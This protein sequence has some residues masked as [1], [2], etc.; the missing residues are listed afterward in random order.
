MTGVMGHH[1]NASRTELS[2]PITNVMMRYDAAMSSSSPGLATRRERTRAATLAEI[3]QVALALMRDQGTTDV[4]FT[5]IARAMGL[6]APALYRYYADRDALLTDLITDGYHDLAAELAAARDGLP[7]A[8]GP[9]EHL[10]AVAGAYRSWALGDPQRFAL[11][12]GLPVPGYAAPEEGPTVEAAQRAMANLAEV[13]HR[14][15]GQGLLGEPIIGRVDPETVAGLMEQEKKAH[16]TELPPA[17]RQ[18]M[19]HCWAALHGFVCLEAYG[20][21]DWFTPAA[22]DGL[23]LSQVDLAGRALGLRL[24]RP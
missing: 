1:S 23:F 6:T 12:F 21:L 19:M 5:D 22:R 2:S 24:T 15:A 11:I 4:R 18:A 7:A 20:H 13:V 14:A 9:A 3:K 17:T 8:A 10:L 16:D